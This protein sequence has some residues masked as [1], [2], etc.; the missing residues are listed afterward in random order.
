M[1]RRNPLSRAAALT[2]PLLVAAGVLA[3]LTACSG[4]TGPDESTG[5]SG[6]TAA[7]AQDGR[8][9]RPS[10]TVTVPV[11]SAMPADVA[12]MVLP[13]TGV[14]TRWTQGLDAFGRLAADT[15]VR[16]CLTERKTPAPPHEP[17]AF[18]RFSDIPDLPF[19]ARNGFNGVIVPGA[20]DSSKD[21]PAEGGAGQEVQER[22]MQTGMAVDQGLRSLYLKVQGQWFQEES[23]LRNHPRVVAALRGFGPC[24][25][26]HKVEARDENAFFAL[27]DQRLQAGDTAGE[28]AL[29]G[30]YAVCMKPVEDVRSE[31]RKPLAARFRADHR[32]EIAALNTA[33]PAK[34]HELE[35]RYSVRISFPAL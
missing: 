10:P 17:P 31:L 30:A 13:T 34:I 8:A 12:D 22:C 15:A 11:T 1:P 24:L 26:G 5:S 35:R 28:H 3:G 23:S 6:T 7:P 27:V 29:A 9:Q 25:A 16:G 18:V 19:I 32:E 4:T 2:A 20:A 14:Q 21:R 33:L